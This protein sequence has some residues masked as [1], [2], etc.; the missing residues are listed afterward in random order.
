MTDDEFDARF[1]A[2]GSIEPPARLV[3]KTMAAWQGERGRGASRTRI[4]A[5]VG[6]AAMAALSLLVVSDP[7]DR[8]DPALMVERGT[9]DNRPTVTIKAAIRS[10]SGSV[11]RFATNQRYAAGDTLMLRVQCSA[12]AT[13]T[14]RREG[15]VLWSGSV[16]AGETDLPVSYAFEAGEGP[17]RFIVEGGAETQ[18]VYVPAVMP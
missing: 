13:V 12:P 18:T 4:F 9:G 1:G 3:D 10:N 11:E 16:P 15:V 17:A 8:G 2:L 7:A 14:L 5:G 6:M